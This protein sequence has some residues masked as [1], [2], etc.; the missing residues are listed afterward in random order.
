M[1]AVGAGMLGRST[2]Y[3]FLGRMVLYRDKPPEKG[4]QPMLAPLDIFI[5]MQDRTY[6]WKAVADSFELAK[7]KVEQLAANAPGE[8]MIFNQTTGNKIVVK[9]DGSPDLAA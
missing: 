5:K 4:T 8:Y 6:V 7:S 1:Y 3:I 2:R 9:P